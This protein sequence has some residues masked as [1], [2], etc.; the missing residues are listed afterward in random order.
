M[1]YT[2]YLGGADGIEVP[3]VSFAGPLTLIASCKE[4]DGWLVV[5]H[6]AGGT[7]WSSVGGKHPYAPATFRVWRLTAESK[8]AGNKTAWKVQELLEFPARQ[9]FTK[10]G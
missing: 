7:Y 10:R 4:A 9:K 2:A 3:G 6:I 8:P 5:V 1:H